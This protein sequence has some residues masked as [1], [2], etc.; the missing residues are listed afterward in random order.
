[1]MSEMATGLFERA[2][3][4][5]GTAALSMAPKESAIADAERVGQDLFSRLGVDS[6]EQARALSWI[7]IIQSE[8]DAMVPR[9]VYRPTVDNHYLSKTY[10]ETLVGG[11]PSDVPL[12]VG[13]TTGD[14]PS[15]RTGLQVAM[16][17]RAEY[18]RAPLY[19]YQ[20]TRVPAGLAKK[21]VPS[22]HG[23]ELPYLFNYPEMFVNNYRFNLVLDPETGMKPEIA[24]L[25]QD[26]TT[27][28]DGD[29]EDILAALEWDTVDS[30]YA[31]TVMTVWTNF[32][33]TGSP[34]T[35]T[36]NW[37]A[38]TTGNDQLVEFGQSTVE[39]KG[40]LATAF[41]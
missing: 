13:A 25:D 11:Q 1:M 29:A 27:G 23:C 10:Y 18:S 32:A 21:A 30:Q 4:Q 5:S 41:P 39:V 15:L 12:M 38:Y 37:P 24:D 19:V 14:Y 20:F 16:P 17:V 40:G 6:V 35:D 3:C 33:K 9:E 8:I 31:D 26:G 22:C 28:T 34:N 7:E 2:I 36:L